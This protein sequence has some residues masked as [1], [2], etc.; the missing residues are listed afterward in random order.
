MPALWRRGIAVIGVAVAVILAGW[1]GVSFA[2]DSTTTTTTP[3]GGQPNAQAGPQPGPGPRFHGGGRG[4]GPGPDFGG[5]GMGRGAIHGQ[6]TVPNGSDFRT[7]DFQ[8]GKV[9]AVSKD[10]ITVESDDKFSKTYAVT[11]NTLVVAGQEGIGSVK[12]G[13]VVRITAVENGKTPEAM[14]IDDQTTSQAIHEHWK[15]APPPSSTTTTTG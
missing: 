1:I 14:Q 13:D 7:I 9:T 3:P 8:R 4:H 6:Y 2:A 12:N 10:S 15:P 11:A 5:P